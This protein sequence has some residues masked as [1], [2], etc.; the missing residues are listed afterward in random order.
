MGNFF[1][2]QNIK[3]GG[4]NRLFLCAANPVQ[5]S[6]KQKSA[7]SAKSARKFLKKNQYNLR[8]ILTFQ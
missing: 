7:T 1:I 8:E 6:Y 5:I 2:L 4:N 3:K